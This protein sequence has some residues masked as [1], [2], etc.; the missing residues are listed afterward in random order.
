MARLV[1]KAWNPVFLEWFAQL[2]TAPW[3]LLF[4]GIFRVKKSKKLSEEN[5]SRGPTPDMIYP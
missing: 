3:N 4:C 5:L 1:L 2:L